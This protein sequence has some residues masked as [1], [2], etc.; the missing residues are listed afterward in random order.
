MV[1]IHTNSSSGI[2]HLESD[3]INP[4]PLISWRSVV[5]GL[6]ISFFTL[7]ALLSL[8]LAVGGISIDADTSAKGAGI[9]TGVWFIVS[10]LISLFI[11]SYFAARV[12]KFRTSRVGSAQ[13]LVI[14]SLFVGFFIYQTAAT[15]GQA[16]QAV[17]S[18]I[19]GSANMVSQGVEKASESPTVSNTVA[20]ISEDAIGNL[21]LKADPKTVAT[22]VASRLVRGDTESAKN[23]LAIQ[24]GISPMEAD[25]RIAQMK[26]RVDQ[27]ADDAKMAAATTL[28]SVG[29]SLLII[30]VLGALAS[31]AGGALGSVANFKKP[32]IT[33]DGVNLRR[34]QTAV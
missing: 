23:Y 16:G 33:Q 3:S 32:L 2:A 22:G 14:A 15:I 6:L 25:A 18:F 12:S 30:T 10:A 26:A 13:G 24:A 4:H 27:M 20:S 31:V 5:A 21:N 29:W 8:G 1:H 28:K 9:F 7:T 11:G 34:T 17:G 19:K